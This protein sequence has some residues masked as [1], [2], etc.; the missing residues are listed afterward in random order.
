MSS[1]V[2]YDYDIAVLVWHS[3][4]ATKLASLADFNT[5]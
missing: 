5:I 2:L 1:I 3:N 4:L